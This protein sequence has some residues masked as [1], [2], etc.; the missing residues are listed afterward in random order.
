MG[1]PIRFL[2]LPISGSFGDE[3]QVQKAP[4]KYDLDPAWQHRRSDRCTA[5]VF[6][7]FAGIQFIDCRKEFKPSLKFGDDVMSGGAIEW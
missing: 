5:F 7:F 4:M 1:F 2:V 6:S 3:D